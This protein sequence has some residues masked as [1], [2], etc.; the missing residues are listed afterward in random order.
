MAAVPT[1]LRLRW[2]FQCGVAKVS[3]RAFAIMPNATAAK[4][5]RQNTSSP[6]LK[7]NF[8]A[9]ALMHTFMTVKP[10]AATII[11][12]EPRGSLGVGVVI[13]QTSKEERGV[14]L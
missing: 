1:T 10:S 4:L 12:A 11:H 5:M 9:A 3:P 7:L 13:Y 2:V 8:A 6:L 14:W